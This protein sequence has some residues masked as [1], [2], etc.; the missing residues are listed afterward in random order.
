MIAVVLFAGAASAEELCYKQPALGLSLESFRECRFSRLFD[1]WMAD[2][3]FSLAASDDPFLPVWQ[4]VDSIGSTLGKVFLPIEPARPA[5]TVNIIYVVPKALNDQMIANV[6]LRPH[7]FDGLA[8]KLSSEGKTVL[9]DTI[10]ADEEVFVAAG[11]VLA[12]QVGFQPRFVQHNAPDFF[13]VVE[14]E[15]SV[16]E[17]L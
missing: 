2:N 4:G 6:R 17:A 3:G 5:A 10:D 15:Q 11:G 1:G 16:C 14:I 12:F 7:F 8:Q 13:T 9:C